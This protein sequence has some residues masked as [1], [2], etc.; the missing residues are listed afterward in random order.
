MPANVSKDNYY[1]TVNIIIFGAICVVPNNV[2][3]YMPVFNAKPV[4]LL[5]AIYAGR[6]DK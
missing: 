6:G 5:N 1:T 3:M 4:K 2:Y